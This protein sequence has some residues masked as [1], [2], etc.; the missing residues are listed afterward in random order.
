MTVT[1]SSTNEAPLRRIRR[2]LDL[3]QTD[4]ATLC[5]ISSH[6]VTLAEQGGTQRLPGKILGV[7]ADLGYDPDA[8]AAEHEKFMADRREQ[9]LKQVKARRRNG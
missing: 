4:L 7:L 6:S 9:L 1:K 5:Q 2:E 8:L 3:S